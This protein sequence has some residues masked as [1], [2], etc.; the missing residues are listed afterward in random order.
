M[1]QKE[2]SLPSH[3]FGIQNLKGDTTGFFFPRSWPE[4]LLR[5]KL[6]FRCSRSNPFTHI[7][8][9]K[10]MYKKD[11]SS[12]FPTV[13]RLQQ[14]L[15]GEQGELMPTTLETTTAK[16]LPCTLRHRMWNIQV[17][18]SP[19]TSPSL[20]LS[21]ALAL[22]HFGKAQLQYHVRNYF[23]A[24]SVYSKNQKIPEISTDRLLPV[25]VVTCTVP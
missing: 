17:W 6:V 14:A 25:F 12:V 4:L 10:F 20:F 13:L 5:T 24:A 15:H 7:F 18:F 8:L 19:A 11:K 22:N 9:N 16:L 21:T 2:T 3:T 23:G 1:T